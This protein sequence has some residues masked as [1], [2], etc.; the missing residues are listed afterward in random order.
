[1]EYFFFLL[2][3]RH[4]EEPPKV[5][6]LDDIIWRRYSELMPSPVANKTQQ[7][8]RLSD[9]GSEGKEADQIVKTIG[10]QASDLTGL[11]RFVKVDS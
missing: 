7:Q 11:D 8:Q 5:H 10:L 2:R 3:F 1:M 4:A 9:L 6:P